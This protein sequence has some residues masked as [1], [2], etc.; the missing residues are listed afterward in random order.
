MVIEKISGCNIGDVDVDML[1][2]LLEENN[3]AGERFVWPDSGAAN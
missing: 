2:D 3:D 1:T